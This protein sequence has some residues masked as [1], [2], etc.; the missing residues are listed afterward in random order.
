MSPLNIELVPKYAPPAHRNAPVVELVDA[1]V[2]ASV[3][4]ELTPVSARIA[5][6]P[7]NVTFEPKNEANATPMPP[8]TVRAPVVELVDAVAFVAATVPPNKVAPVAT[9]S[10]Y[11]VPPVVT[12]GAPAINKVDA[13]PLKVD[14]VVIG[15]VKYEK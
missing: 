2:L 12:V 6:V 14:T 9:C 5:D 15:A 1:V 4:V 8:D 11:P 7:L 3:S 13:V 10:A